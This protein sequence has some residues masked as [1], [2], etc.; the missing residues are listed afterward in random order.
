MASLYGIVGDASPTA[1]ANAFF[2]VLQRNSSEAIRAQRLAFEKE[3]ALQQEIAEKE[4]RKNAEL[5]VKRE[6]ARMS[7]KSPTFNNNNNNSSIGQT[8]GEEQ[9]QRSPSSQGPFKARAR[10]SPSKNESYLMDEPHD[11]SNSSAEGNHRQSH[12]RPLSALSFS[13]LANEKV[14][15]TK[16]EYD[17]KQKELLEMKVAQ[18]E[19]QKGELIAQRAQQ[20]AKQRAALSKEAHLANEE[21][22]AKA[23]AAKEAGIRASMEASRQ[24]QEN[25]Q[26][27]MEKADERR[28]L[29]A[30]EARQRLKMRHDLEMEH[31]SKHAQMKHEDELRREEKARQMMEK[32]SR[33]QQES[34]S[35]LLAAAEN[36]RQKAEKVAQQRERLEEAQ[37]RMLMHL[38]QKKQQ[39]GERVGAMERQR[40]KHR[41]QVQSCLIQ[42]RKLRDALDMTMR[43]LA[44][45]G[46][47]DESLLERTVQ[48]AS[49]GETR[50]LSTTGDTV[51]DEHT[52]KVRAGVIRERRCALCLSIFPALAMRN[53]TT[54]KNV[55]DLRRKWGVADRFNQN[56][57]I[58]TGTM[59]DQ[60][61]VCVFCA[62]FFDPEA[63]SDPQQC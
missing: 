13:A 43:Q 8:M 27:N 57:G 11:R 3:R 4:Q 12:G 60:V 23:L 18:I 49:K 15:L 32:L 48:S 22:R 34:M 52:N 55:L 59:Y 2:K 62:Q 50:P 42:E 54:Q 19:K 31:A 63:A 58:R 51:K 47:Y 9:E 36:Q 37:R 45:H 1:K 7:V 35:N 41:Q 46:R 26:K 14:R 20:V 38:E 53:T 16:M 5:A 33:Q 44:M 25:E 21:K 17:R 28:R 30:E 39:H 29:L 10:T 61:S 56:K 24:I 40:E 6:V